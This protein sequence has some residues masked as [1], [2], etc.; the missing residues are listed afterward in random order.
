MQ[1]VIAGVI[2]GVILGRATE[3]RHPPQVQYPPV[4]IVEPHRPHRPH[5]H[6]HPQQLPQ[7]IQTPGIMCP[8][9]TAPMYE[10]RYDAYGR[11]YYSFMGCR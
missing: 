5:Y 7:V 3:Q 4:V 8:A 2:V 9:G 6:P 11:H 10:T 1:D